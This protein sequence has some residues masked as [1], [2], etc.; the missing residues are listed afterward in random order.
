MESLNL[1]IVQ[2]VTRRQRRGAE[3]FAAD[4][5]DV[6]ARRGH[7]VRYAGLTAPP[8]APLVPVAGCAVDVSAAS[9]SSLNLRLVADLAY[10]LRA[11][12][13]D[14]VQANGGFAMKYAVLAKLWSRADWPILYCNIG[15]SS[16]WL[17][18]PGQRVWN[19]WLLRHTGATAAVSEASR[20][21][22]I[23]TYGLDPERVEV[24][25]RGIRTDLAHERSAGRVALAAA[26]VPA[27]A[28]VVL[29]VGSFSEEKNHEGLLRIVER[30]RREVPDVHLALVGDGPL[31]PSIE[32]KAPSHVHVL[33]VRD[34]V[35][36]LMAGADVFLLPSLTEG[37][38]GVLLEAGAERLPAVAYDVGGVREAVEDGSTGY[39]IAKGDEAAAAAAVCRLVQDEDLRRKIGNAARTFV[40]AHY[41]LERS[42]DGFEALCYMLAGEPVPAE[43]ADLVSQPSL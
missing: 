19:R 5:T 3:V 38:P 13:P 30:V 37:I 43:L 26:G 36:R 16:D 34:D 22:L 23:T 33:G 10:Y 31:R 2:L 4:L 40:C 1:R 12:D 35:R 14:V 9:P 28:P 17:R 7:D 27:T 18:R 21:D 15:L 25:R 32:A 41:D 42:A 39:V 29:H 6:L 24:V 20:A 8:V 11:V